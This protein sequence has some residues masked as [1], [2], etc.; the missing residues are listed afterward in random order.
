GLLVVCLPL[1]SHLPTLGTPL[2]RGAAW[3]ALVPPAWFLGFQRGLQGSP[4]P[5]V[6]PAHRRGHLH[7]PVQTCRTADASSGAYVTT[8]VE[9]E[10]TRA[11]F[12]RHAPIQ[13]S[14]RIYRCDTGPE[15]V[16]PGRAHWPVGMRSRPRHHPLDVGAVDDVSLDRAVPADVRLWCRRS[17]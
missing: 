7:R 10:S 13:R 8:L 2:S 12:P 17:G 1:V 4:G 5:K 6:R 9:H 15:S 11:T 16:A 14:L 3:M